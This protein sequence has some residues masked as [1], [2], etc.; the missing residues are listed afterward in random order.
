MAVVLAR[1][2]WLPL[3]LV[4]AAMAQELQPLGRGPFWRVARPMARNEVFATADGCAA[5]SDF[6]SPV[7]APYRSH[8]FAGANAFLLDLFA[9]NRAALQVPASEAALRLGQE[10]RT[11][12]RRGAR[13]A[14]LTAPRR[15]T[16]TGGRARRP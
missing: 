5:C 15:L 11:L 3:L 10:A 12:R 16:S 2:L 4:G 1:A 9:D 8:G 7:R 14:A 13:R 6:L